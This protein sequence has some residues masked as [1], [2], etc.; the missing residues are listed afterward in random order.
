RARKILELLPLSEREN[1]YLLDL[2]GYPTRLHRSILPTDA[3]MSIQEWV[4]QAILGYCEIEGLLCNARFL[5]RKLA[6]TPRKIQQKLNTLLKAGLLEKRAD[7]SLFRRRG[8]SWALSPNF[9]PEMRQRHLQDRLKLSSFAVDRL[10]P[11]RQTMVLFNYAGNES[12]LLRLRQEIEKICDRLTLEAD[13][14]PKDQLMHLMVHA[15]P[16][17]FAPADKEIDSVETKPV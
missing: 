14:G 4:D 17:D 16:I 7:G 9:T 15:F 2:M 12:Q 10:P 11:E 1:T 3:L 5:A 6:S 13:Q 8:T